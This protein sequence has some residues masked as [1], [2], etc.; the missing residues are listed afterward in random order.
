[1][2]RLPPF[3]LLLAATCAAVA[4]AQLSENYYGSSCPAALL[5]VRTTVATAVL[6]DRR[7]GA[8]LLRLY[9]HDC[10]VQGCDASV[11]LDDTPS[12]T[13]EKGAGPNAGSLRGFEVIDR[14]KLLLELICP[15][16]VSCAD[17]LAVAAHDAVVDV[18]I[19]TT[20]F[21]GLPA[22]LGGPSWTVLLGRRDATTASASLANSDLPGPN[23]NLND[24]L[25]AFSK[26]GLSS[27]DMVALSGGH[28]IG[29]AQCQNYRNRI[30]A[31]TDIDGTFTA[32]LR[33]DCPQGGGN[34]GNLAPLDASSPDY[35]DNSY[36]SGLLSHRGLLHSDQA[37]Y[38]G[39]STDGLVSSYASN[40]DQFGS[41]FAA[42]MVKLGNL[43]VLTGAYGEIRVNCRA[44]N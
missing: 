12:F 19:S 38:D 17:I 1:M 36:F 26:K 18:T 6:L 28:T 21:V 41:D 43:G 8:S 27:T 13:G 10:F 34:D 42:A 4:N 9:F 31:D 37:L 44:V 2:A 35:F 33:G 30:Y 16:T 5:T 20:C 40:N 15:R 24:L 25:A 7:M 32:S 23:S 11:L 14:I 39:G 29:R 3:L 22:Q